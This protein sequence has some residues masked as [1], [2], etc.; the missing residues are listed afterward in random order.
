MRRSSL[1]ILMFA[2]LMPIAWSV[3]PIFRFVQR[4][5]GH[6]SQRRLVAGAA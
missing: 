3:G 2:G 5:A 6:R 4:A 1:L